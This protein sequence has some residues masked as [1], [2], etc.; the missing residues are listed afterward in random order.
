MM[1]FEVIDTGN[2]MTPE[3]TAGLFRPF[4][5]ADSSTSRLFG[6]T[7]LGLTISRQFA[8]MLGGDVV[9]VETQPARG[10]RFR[11]TVTTGWLE[12][13]TMLQRP[14]GAEPAW[15]ET[16]GSP[17]RKLDCRI[18]LAEDGPDNQRLISFFLTKAGADVIVASNGQEAVDK[19]MGTL[20]RR[21]GSDA[22][23]PFDLILMDMQMPI[24]DGYT[25]TRLLREQ[26]YTG[27]IVALT[28]HAMAGEREKCRAAGCDEY[29]TK[30]IDRE[31]LI[32]ACRKYICQCAATTP[33]GT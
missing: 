25:A 27:T 22:D 33:V 30:P 3:E 21:R 23:K 20:L 26:A 10:S 12:G 9:L 6:G 5:Q 32:A 1:Q 4:Q 13:V 18:L 17:Q 11:L 15:V 31:K 24:M 28:A 19:V 8:R 14:S 2:G 16:R 29:L 7:G